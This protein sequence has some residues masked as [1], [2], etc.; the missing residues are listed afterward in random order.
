MRYDKQRVV[1]GG[2][3]A[4]QCCMHLLVCMWMAEHVVGG[5]VGGW[6][7]AH[8]HVIV[9]DCDCDC[10]CVCVCVCVGGGVCDLEH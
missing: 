7:G 1:R 4:L 9:R 10:V 5:R 8:M 2:G 6:V 3:G